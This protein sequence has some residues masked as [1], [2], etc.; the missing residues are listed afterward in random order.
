VALLFS[1]ISP[2]PMATNSVMQPVIN[3]LPPRLR[4]ISFEVI[5]HINCKIKHR[6]RGETNPGAVIFRL[7]IPSLGTRLDFSRL[8]VPGSWPLAIATS[9]SD[10]LLFTNFGVFLPWCLTPCVVESEARRACGVEWGK[11]EDGVL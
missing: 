8:Y 3:G 6:S 4:Q 5:N 11:E 1:T 2:P 7:C 10:H 9:L